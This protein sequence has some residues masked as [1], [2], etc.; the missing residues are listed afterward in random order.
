MLIWQTLPLLMNWE[1]ASGPEYGY[2]SAGKRFA[3]E[4]VHTAAFNLIRHLC[5]G[6]MSSESCEG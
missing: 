1:I 3:R 6:L 4:R 5:S 2:I